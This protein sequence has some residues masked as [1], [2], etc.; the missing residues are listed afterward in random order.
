IGAWLG[1]CIGPARFEVG[2]E[3]VEACG[4][5]SDR[6]VPGQ[7]GKWFA[8]LAG[9]AA[10]RLRAAGVKT[11]SADRWCTATDRSRFF[12]YRRDRLTGRQ[13]ALV[14]IDPRPSV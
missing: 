10:D 3:V 13:A 2:P 4:G 1:P 5:P 11:I 6:F 8:D 7:P 14:W 12:S 9:L